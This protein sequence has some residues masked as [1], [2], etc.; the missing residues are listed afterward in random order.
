M[1]NSCNVRDG[2]R[3]MARFFIVAIGLCWF[4][5]PV[6][7]VGGTAYSALKAAQKDTDRSASLLEVT[8]E[9][10]EPQPQ[11]WKVVFRDPTAR[12]GIREVTASGDVV[13]SQRTPLKGY[14]DPDEAPIALARLNLD[15]DRAFDI[16]NKQATAR[17]ISFSWV[18]YSLR[19]EDAS[20][21][22]IWALRLYN[23]MGLNVGVIQIS[24]ENGSV[25][26]PLQAS[27][28][29]PTEPVEQFSDTTTGRRIGGFMGRVGGTLENVGKGVRDT[30]LRTV[31]R[32]QEFLT[33]E[34]TIGPQDEDE[35]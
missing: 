1:E 16:A 17:R 32:V 9:R 7:A 20:G 2:F 25:L 4:V 10:G 22:P 29:P 12:G 18:D 30:T 23:N 27:A 35:E 24:A 33:G 14:T 31:G 11:E 19:T 3:A 26:M 28:P 8:G 15:S 21:A 34:R 13:V 5:V 6:W